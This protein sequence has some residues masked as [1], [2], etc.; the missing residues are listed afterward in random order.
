MTVSPVGGVWASRA[1][2]TARRSAGPTS[3][4]RIIAHPRG[5]SPCV[6]PYAATDLMARLLHATTRGTRV[7]AGRGHH[8]TLNVPNRHRR[9]HHSPSARSLGPRRTRRDDHAEPTR[10]KK[11]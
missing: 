4:A 9:H 2:G 11:S 6:Q 1:T 5:V 7:I 8:H 3:L 10:A